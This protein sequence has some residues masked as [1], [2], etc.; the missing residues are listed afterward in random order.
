MEQGYE[1]DLAKNYTLSSQELLTVSISLGHGLWCSKDKHFLN[2]THYQ[3]IHG[4]IAPPLR[5]P[6]DL[7]ALQQGLRMGIIM[8]IE[9]L[10]GDELHLVQLLEKQILPLFDIGQMTAFRWERHGFSGTSH[11]YTIPLPDFP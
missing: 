4:H 10:A 6:A 2:T 7:R 11:T 1:D 3:K 5:T 9:V 8:G